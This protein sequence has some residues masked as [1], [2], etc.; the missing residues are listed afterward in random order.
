MERCKVFSIAYPKDGKL[1]TTEHFTDKYVI[2]KLCLEGG[3]RGLCF[4][5]V[6]AYDDALSGG[7]TT[8]LEDDA[9][10]GSEL[11][12]GRLGVCFGCATHAFGLGDA[13]FVHDLVRKEF[14]GFELGRV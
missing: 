3:Q 4:C 6:V 12:D 1:G 8:G 13:E 9:T 2:S 5:L 11:L 14:I 10:L 7:E